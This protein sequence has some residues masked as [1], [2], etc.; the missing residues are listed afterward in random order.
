MLVCAVGSL[1]GPLCLPFFPVCLS[2]IIG[3]A[4]WNPSP[5]FYLFIFFWDRVSLCSPGCPGTHSVDQAGLELR[6]PPASDSQV[7]GLMACATTARLPFSNSLLSG[8]M[9]FM[10]LCGLGFQMSRPGQ[11]WGWKDY[12][13]SRLSFP[14]L[15]KQNSRTFHYFLIWCFKLLLYLVCP[16]PT[17]ISFKVLGSL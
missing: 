5:L 7:L 12:Y 16:G 1:C 2:G 4:L 9:L 15:K 14:H 3:F 17:R 8:C 6:N 13:F 11:R 10:C